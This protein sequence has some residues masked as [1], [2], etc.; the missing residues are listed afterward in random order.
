M[1]KDLESRGDIELLVN[2]FYASVQKDDMIGPIFNDVAKVDWN[3]HLPK[4]YNFFE[5][6]LLG[7]RGFKGNPMEVHFSLNQ[8]TPLLPEHFERWQQL[9]SRAVDQL[10]EGETAEEAKQKAS[11]IANLMMF[12]INSPGFNIGTPGRPKQN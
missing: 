6:I 5:T 12:R 9:F 10:F 3:H 7:G 11:S 4:M 2:T 8:K 1:K